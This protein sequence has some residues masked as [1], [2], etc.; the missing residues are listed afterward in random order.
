[1]DV[2]KEKLEQMDVEKEKL[3]E[4]MDV[5]KEKLEE[6]M[7]AEKENLVGDEAADDDLL[8]EEPM[9][10]ASEECDGVSA[11]DCDIPTNHEESTI[12]SSNINTNENSLTS[13][14]DISGDTMDSHKDLASDRKSLLSAEE[15]TEDSM[16]TSASTASDVMNKDNSE[17]VEG[18]SPQSPSAC[19]LPSKDMDDLAD[20]PGDTVEMFHD[21]LQSYFTCYTTKIS[22]T[23]DFG[24]KCFSCPKCEKTELRGENLPKHLQLHIGKEVSVISVDGISTDFPC[25]LPSNVADSKPQS[26][27]SVPSPAK[28]NEFTKT[29][30]HETA[31]ESVT[32]EEKHS[33]Q[34][35]NGYEELEDNILITEDEI[36][37]RY[38]IK[39]M[40]INAETRVPFG[41]EVLKCRMCAYRTMTIMD[42]PAHIEVHVKKAVVLKK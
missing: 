8:G 21:E 4:Q 1:M 12:G 26:N 17:M 20:R 11:G 31:S 23:K 24:L 28:V 13:V 30:S 5:E 38:F 37:K 34:M 16:E 39:D 41:I 15:N 14:D 29:E 2:E 9:E 19:T 22:Q 7:D 6:Q 32:D 36:L 42:T 10:T 35:T 25:V 27:G 3:E 33:E 40:S 18:S